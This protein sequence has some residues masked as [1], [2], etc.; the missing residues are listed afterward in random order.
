MTASGRAVDFFAN[1]FS[2]AVSSF[3]GLKFGGLKEIEFHLT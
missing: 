3:Q 1:F 2:A